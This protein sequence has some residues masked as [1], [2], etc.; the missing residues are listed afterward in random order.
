ME[1]YIKDILNEY[2]IFMTF[3]QCKRTFELN[4][5]YFTYISCVQAVRSYTFKTGLT[6]DKYYMPDH[7]INTLKVIY[8]RRKGARPY[9]D[10]RMQ[11]VDEQNA[12]EVEDQNEQIYQLEYW[13]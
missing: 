9:Y 11:D 3:N 7:L 6:V 5:N 2:G 10:V 8:S 13:Y 12:W 1:S 4:T